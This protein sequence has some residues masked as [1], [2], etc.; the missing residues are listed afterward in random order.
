MT[1]AVPRRPVLIAA[2]ALAV[3]ATAAA[4]PASAVGPPGSASGAKASGGP[5]PRA[6]ATGALPPP[7]HHGVL[8]I[9]GSPR[10]GGTLR[11][12]G[13]TWRP[14]RLPAGDR[15]LSFQVGY[16]WDACTTAGNCRPGADTTATP[17]AARRYVAG[18]ADT[19]RFLKVT[20][21]A[22]EVVET[23][24]ATFSFVTK[25]VSVSA[26]SRG[27]VR[28][29]RA[30]L[31][32]RTAFVNGTPE[33]RTG[34][35]AEYFSVAAPHYNTADGPVT[36]RYRVDHRHW[37]ALPPRGVFYTGMLR[38]GR[39]RV[40]VR[41]T[42]AAGASTARFAWRVVPLPAPLACQ[43]VPGRSCWYP[44]HLDARG[45][46]ARWDWQIG[47][48]APLQ[49]TGAHAV[50]IYDI[51]G[52]LT[53]PAQV[54][55]IHTRWQAATLPHPKAVCYLDLAWEDYR[56]DATVGQFFPAATLGN[57]YFGF[58]Q[59][60]WV[61]F[62]QLDALK[63][64]LDER[65]RMCAAKGFDTV[66]LDDIDSFDPPSTTGFHLTPGDAQNYLAYAFNE[67]HR[68]GMTGLW[69]NS[70]LLSWWGRRYAD[71][72]VVEECYRY[73]E[74]F[75]AQL[76]GSSQYGITCTG[77][78]GRTPCGW[79]DFSTDRTAA[80]PTGKWVGEAEYGADHYVCNP[81]RPCPPKRRFATFC[82]L[83]Y[84]PPGGYAA[85]KFDVDL[86]GTMFFP[87]P[88]GT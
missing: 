21:A 2:V 35:A 59:E 32:P 39:H 23:D 7:R 86:N 70:P 16:T 55:A 82:R 50:D 78:A 45:H 43:A 18:H 57:V 15:L 67:I 41:T 68:Y 46:P 40:A 22:T 36:Q 10:D 52:F 11:A 72:A 61:D 60:R 1:A 9:T 37:R 12:A 64:M 73:H 69:K 42:D 5:S 38:A 6:S 75:A 65:I 27:A 66:E 87:C 44:P 24:P 48:V 17:F 26:A 20:E 47:R 83:V 30:G 31:P 62:R 81:G 3:A 77:L 80:Q 71:G 76:R 84:A 54:R 13:L 58:P 29:Y 4:A 51:D 28:A 53:T 49:R 14:G 63:P 85:V 56:P 19:G 25:S 74:C 88:H 79:D 8:R 33:R 34:S